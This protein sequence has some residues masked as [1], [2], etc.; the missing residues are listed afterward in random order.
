MYVGHVTVLSPGNGM[1]NNVFNQRY[2]QWIVIILVLQ[3]ALF[4]IP[5]FMWKIWENG[6]LEQL[7]RNLNETAILT[8][9]GNEKYKK[10]LIQYFLLDNN[11]VHRIYATRFLI[12]EIMNFF[13]IVS[14][15]N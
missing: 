2:Y 12:C 15:N 11:N 4:Y 1:K 9:D 7:C 13:I 3:A 14:I 5:A 6:R 10:K 8:E